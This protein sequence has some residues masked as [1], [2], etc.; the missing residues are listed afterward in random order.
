MMQRWGSKAWSDINVGLHLFIL[1]QRR[2]RGSLTRCHEMADDL[3]NKVRHKT[4]GQSMLQ[5]ID[6]LTPRRAFT[7]PL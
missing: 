6:P 2:L 5:Q 3:A 7:I 1:R 4:L